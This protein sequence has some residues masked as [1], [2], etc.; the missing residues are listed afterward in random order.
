MTKHPSQINMADK[1]KSDELNKL[2]RNVSVSSGI[3]TE[4]QV[5]YPYPGTHFPPA[6]TLTC[7]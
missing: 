6:E 4:L 2:E 3:G 5:H 7:A 1:R